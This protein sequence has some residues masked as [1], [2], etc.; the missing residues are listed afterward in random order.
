VSKRRVAVKKVSNIFAD[1]FDAKRILREIRL[2]RH[3]S[4]HEN[5]VTIQN[6]ITSAGP[7]DDVYIVTDL[8]ESDLEKILSSQQQLDDK[9]YR[10]FLYQ[11]CS[12]IITHRRHLHNADPSW[13][14]VH[15]L[16]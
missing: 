5:I 2:L 16:G 6:L 8:M 4:Q 14:Q 9:H 10:Y 3:F 13:P 11:V 12:L 15:P 1:I 7:F